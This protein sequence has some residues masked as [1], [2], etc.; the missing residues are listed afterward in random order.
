MALQQKFTESQKK[1]DLRR[2]EVLRQERAPWVTV[3]KQLAE[4]ILPRRFRDSAAQ[5]NR[6][7]TNDKL[8][9]NTPTQAARTLAS[10]LM[11]GLTSPARPWFRLGSRN[12]MKGLSPAA[13]MYF[14]AVEDVLRELLIRSNVYNGLAHAFGDLGTFCTAA[15]LIE[16]DEQEVIRSYVLA[17]GTFVLACS[18]RGQVDTMMREVP[19]TVGQLVE[20][21]GYSVCSPQVRDSHDRGDLDRVVEVI[22]VVEPNPKRDPQKLSPDAM[23]FRS[24]WF[25]KKGGDDNTYL[26]ESGF[27]EFPVLA[28]R[29]NVTGNDTYGT[30]PGFDALGDAK[31]LQLLEKRKATLVDLLTKPP[32]AAPSSLRA[33][34]PSLLPGDV[35]YVDRVSGSQGFE[36]LIKVESGAIAAIDQTIHQHEDRIQRA[37]Y[38]D[39]WLAL[40]MDDRNQRA[41]AR[42][43]AERHEE[44]LL[45]LGPVLERLHDELLDKLIDRVYGIALRRGLLPLPPPEL[46]GSDVHVEYISVMAAAQR[47]LGV[48][49]VERLA[50]F[51]GNL[52]SASPETLD[53]VNL[54]KVV[55]EYADMLGTKPE[56]LRSD[57]EVAQ[58]RQ[59]RAAAQQ[60][61]QQAELA[62]KQGPALAQSAQVLSQTD[63][64]GTSALNRLLAV[65][66]GG[67]PIPGA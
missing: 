14:A 25:E 39:L 4:H 36:P 30:G 18:A 37:F 44:K 40:T 28:P 64:N 41:T 16:E 1:R 56:L 47:L 50:S 23:A 19:F 7:A 43:V 8:I 27:H 13:K 57:A 24:A 42:E 67:A 11:G 51:V 38:A 60:K 3:W 35:T 22:H 49:A 61:Q 21:F 29:W 65:Q 58:M 26:R 48:S 2:Y 6:P 20:Q 52:V 33:G 53:K 15:L 10:G 34:R 31:A 66:G 54:D 17:L 55:D 59:A 62:L 9:N 46:Q 63:V 5:R 45:A 12:P 32:M